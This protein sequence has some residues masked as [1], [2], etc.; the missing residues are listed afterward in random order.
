MRQSSTVEI[1]FFKCLFYFLRLDGGMDLSSNYLQSALCIQLVIYV[2]LIWFLYYTYIMMKF[3][4]RKIWQY[5]C[6]Q[7]GSRK[8]DGVENCSH[9][10][11]LFKS[12]WLMTFIRFSRLYWMLIIFI[13]QNTYTFLIYQLVI[14]PLTDLIICFSE[15]IRRTDFLKYITQFLFQLY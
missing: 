11:L 10:D 9:D 14:A 7:K 4:G 2:P 12:L 3:R 5:T 1:N 6:S 8:I 15:L 13:A